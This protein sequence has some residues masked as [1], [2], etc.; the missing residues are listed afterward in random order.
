MRPYVYD[1]LKQ[2]KKYYQVVIFTASHKSYADAV[3][4]TLEEE[5]R[6]DVYLTEEERHIIEQKPESERQAAIKELKREQKLIDYRLYREHCYKTSE[7]VFIKDLRILKN[8]DLSQVL[9]VDN[10]VYSFG[11]QLSNGIPI[12]PFYDS[13]TT[14]INDE[15]LV[16]LVYYFSCI[17]ESE[18]VRV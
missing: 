13:H 3:L 10:A 14:N 16:H 12:I 1:C 8:K 15:E 9:I 7:N 18:D 6:R 11:F 2:A 17:V 5:F 4:D